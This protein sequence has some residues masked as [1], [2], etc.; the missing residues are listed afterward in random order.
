MMEITKEVLLA[1]G[2][3]SIGNKGSLEYLAKEGEFGEI[4]YIPVQDDKAIGI[5]QSI[6]EDVLKL[7]FQFVS[8]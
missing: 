3:R 6:S 2:F 7:L 8:N 1:R 4:L 5:V